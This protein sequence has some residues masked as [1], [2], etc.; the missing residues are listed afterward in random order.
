MST[1]TKMSVLFL[2]AIDAGALHLPLHA[3]LAPL[4]FGML[5]EYRRLCRQ[6]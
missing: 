5:G 2:F 3:A 6:P 4:C 1:R